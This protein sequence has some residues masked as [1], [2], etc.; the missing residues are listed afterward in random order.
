MPASRV[1]TDAPSLTGYALALHEGATPVGVLVLVLVLIAYIEYSRRP[2][3]S[4]CL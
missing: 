4:A 1:C 2:A 3:Y